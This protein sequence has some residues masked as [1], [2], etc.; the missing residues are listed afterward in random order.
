VDAVLIT[1]MSNADAR[2]DNVT[3]S[4]VEHL[5]HTNVFGGIILTTLLLYFPH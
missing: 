2:E 4:S 3:K 1:G 5:E